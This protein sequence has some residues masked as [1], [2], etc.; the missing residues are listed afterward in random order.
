MPA[1]EIALSKRAALLAEL[2]A[3][4]R[5][6]REAVFSESPE[7]FCSRLRERWGVAIEPAALLAMEAGDPLAPIEAWLAAWQ[8]M[9]VAD[10][11]AAA[12]RSEA[13]LFLA[14]AARPGGLLAELAADNERAGSAGASGG[15]P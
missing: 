5:A 12:T 2:G 15:R 3:N 6:Q 10:A 14:A 8:A 13:A 9:Q 7:A 11:A 4:L 1:P